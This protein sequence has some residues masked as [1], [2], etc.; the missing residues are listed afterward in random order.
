[1]HEQSDPDGKQNSVGVSL[2]KAVGSS[3]PFSFLEVL[4][5][6]VGFKRRAPPVLEGPVVDDKRKIV[7][8]R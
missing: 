6:L 8:S 1:M 4:V 2:G 7:D 3:V 5:A